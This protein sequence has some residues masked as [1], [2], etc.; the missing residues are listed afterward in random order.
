[1]KASQGSKQ[2]QAFIF[3]LLKEQIRAMTANPSLV[4]VPLHN[5]HEQQSN[6]AQRPWGLHGE[7]KDS[8]LTVPEV[9]LDKM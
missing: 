8:E 2:K 4:Q 9:F 7:M 1:M 3:T 5:T 6:T